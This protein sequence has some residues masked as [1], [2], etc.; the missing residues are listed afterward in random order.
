MTRIRTDMRL[1][2]NTLIY[3]IRVL[4]CLVALSICV[5]SQQKPERQVVEGVVVDQSGDPVSA[6]TVTLVGNSTTTATSTGNDGRFHFESPPQSA[7]ILEISATGFAKIKQRLN[8]TAEVNAPLRV[9]LRPAD[10]EGQVTV[11]ATRIETSIADT[12]ASVVVLGRTA[13][14]TTAALTVDDTLRQ[15]A[16]FS[17]FRRSGSRTANPTTQGVSLRGLGASGA[18]R[19]IVLADGIPLTDPFGGWVYWD[20]VPRVAVAEVEVLRGPASHLYGSDALGGVINITTKP[21]DT[22]TLSL[23]TFYGNE[24]TPGA[25]LFAGH[26]KDDWGG[27]VSA[28]ILNTDGY[29]IVAP[30]ERGPVDTPAGSRHSVVTLRAERWFG[31]SQHIFGDMSFFGEARKNGTPLQTN[32]THIR[33]FSLG[34]ES[35]SSK[36]GSFSAR[37]YGGTQVYDQN[38]SAISVDRST[39]T[40]T[41]VQ[42]VPAQ[43]V[44]GSIQGSSGE[45]HGQTFVAGFESQKVRGASDEIVFVNGRATSQVGAGGREQTFGGYFEDIAMIGSRVFLTAGVRID[46][47]RNNDALSTTTPLTVPTRSTVILFPDRSETAFSPHLSGTYKIS[48]NVSLI[49]SGSRA[50]RAPTLNELYRSFRVGNVLTLANENLRA[51][52]LTGGEAG[53]RATFLNQ[54][55][56]IFGT[57]FWNEVTQPVANVTLQ[58]TP[59]LITRQRQNL[60]RTRSVGVEV[61]ADAQL[62]RFWSLSSGYVLA[63]A[64][65]VRFPANTALE[66]LRIPQVPLH[67]FTFQLRYTNSSIATVGVQARASSSQFDDDQNL[68]RLGS[69]FVLDATVAR[70]ISSH[71][72][73][74]GAA[75]NLFNNRYETGKTPVTTIG[76]PILVRAGVRLQ[77]GSR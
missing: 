1:K 77:F 48:E 74:F 45:W 71:V 73:V 21:R 19:A 68:F 70:R 11:A 27:S 9:V 76:P 50:F 6:A 7:L 29:I 32:R 64:T 4:L 12:P 47:W 25:S 18:S 53:L 38:F 24:R 26:R 30:D 60:G 51:E 61:E 58:T 49:F 33:Q 15:V 35:S 66:G 52:R 59:A 75:E 56:V 72:E 14:A 16:G 20:R 44:G 22:N 8:Q 31:P 40:L 13:L 46:H 37:I 41:R 69:Y 67:Q 23:E 39:E 57:S 42:R 5:V 10:V 63:D 34:G 17:L 28:E 43:V 36:S 65:V 55:L 2:R 54:R 3:V 62:H